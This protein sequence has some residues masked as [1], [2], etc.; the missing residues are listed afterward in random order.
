MILGAGLAGLTLARHLLLETGRTVVVVE[1]RPAPASR[2]KVGESTVQLAGHYLARVL[3]LE[4]IL[5]R[6]HHLKYNLRFHWPAVAA[7]GTGGGERFEDFSQVFWRPF[8]NVC[9]YQ[10]DRNRLERSIE[11]RVAADPRATV[12]RG[13]EDLAVDL[14]PEG[15]RHTVRFRDGEGVARRVEARW[16]IDATGRRRFLAKQLGL[17]EASPIRHGASFAWVE[18]L[19][20]VERLTDRS[21]KEVRTSP[22]RRTLG[23]SPSWLAT[24]HFCGRGWWFWVIPL[25]DRTSLGLVY[26]R[27][28]VDPSAVA[29]AEGLREWVVDHLPLFAA[30]LECRPLVDHGGFRSFAHGCSRTLD[31]S[32]WA[33]T[34]EA[35]RF[36]DPLYS[37]GSDLI[38]LHNT[39][40]V[41]AIEAPTAAERAARC[42]RHERLLRNLHDAYLPGYVEGYRV[43]GDPEAFVL[44]YA[45][46][47]G[48]YF[49]FY[50]F[51]FLN[52]R[53]AD[54]R[55]AAGFTRR[56][57]RLGRI[58]GAVE[59]LIHGFFDWKERH[60]GLGTSLPV[61][62]DLHSIAPLAA[63][64]KAF[65]EIGGTVEDA[66]RV[67]DVQLD[68]LETLARWIAA[69]VAARVEDAP[70]LLEDAG[71][72]GRIRP[73][74][75]PSDPAG[76][77]AL[78]AA[79]DGRRIDW[80]FDAVGLFSRFRS[81]ASIA[82]SRIGP[83]TALR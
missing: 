8:S 65:Y 50:V 2:Q 49:A 23:H 6:E 42:R 16:V 66:L 81:V 82:T 33:M 62:V 29:S 28:A 59:G 47:L 40:I 4:P 52:E 11:E 70:E 60:G 20:D 5:L 19:L 12:W 32:G 80:G 36:S 64:E 24:N 72:V 37:P 30:E 39:L 74:D 7:D 63:T 51:P 77:S 41:D 15:E 43:L 13:S 73:A 83:E 53:F 54:R 10:I 34:G 79:A 1:H 9:S 21:R 22:R 26:E 17:L 48:V 44:K 76:L 14:D 55:F 57:A 56:F 58:N 35:G 38:A 45:W 71:F 27:G 46:E 61:D 68:H 3:D 78:R 75:L 18:G 25:A 69:H 67:L 31:A